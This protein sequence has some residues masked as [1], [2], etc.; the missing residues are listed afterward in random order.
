MG[1]FSEDK[2]NEYGT[3]QSVADLVRII[4]GAAAGVFTVIGT[5][6]TV[7]VKGK[8]GKKNNTDD[9]TKD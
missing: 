6:I 8:K 2:D 4:V 9:T 3:F 7:I 1:S 5:I